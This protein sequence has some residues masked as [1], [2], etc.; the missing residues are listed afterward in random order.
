M[1]RGTVQY[2]NKVTLFSVIYSQIMK[3]VLNFTRKLADK[4]VNVYP[5][6]IFRK[7]TMMLIL[8]TCDSSD[9]VIVR[10]AGVTYLE[11]RP[12]SLEMLTMEIESPCMML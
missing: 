9:Y 6:V 12:Q 3:K 5:L 1:L 8:C 4:S 7:L 2:I 11:G 10:D